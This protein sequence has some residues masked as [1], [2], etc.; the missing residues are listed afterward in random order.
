MDLPGG[1]ARI[2]TVLADRGGHATYHGPSHGFALNID[3]DLSV[4]DSFVACRLADVSMTSLRQLSATEGV[5]VP[6]EAEVRDAIA[7]QLEKQP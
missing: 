2:P 6:A 4:F 5:P 1:L 3:P 7:R